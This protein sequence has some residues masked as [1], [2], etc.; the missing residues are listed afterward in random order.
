MLKLKEISTFYGD[1][2]A[3]FGISLEV[4]EGQVVTLL[5]KNGMGKSTTIRSIM[6]LNPAATGSIYFIGEPI[7]KSYKEL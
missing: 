2:Q 4:R 5:G 3:L 1:S 6:G 7:N